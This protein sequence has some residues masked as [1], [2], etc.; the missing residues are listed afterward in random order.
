[1]QFVPDE[2]EACDGRDVSSF[3]V[4]G[5]ETSCKLNPPSVRVEF[6]YDLASSVQGLSC[7]AN[8]TKVTRAR[9]DNKRQL[10]RNKLNKAIVTKF[11]NMVKP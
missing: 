10:A 4:S 5:A 1:M 8:S 9:L 7:V 11:A 2:E 3:R 6:L